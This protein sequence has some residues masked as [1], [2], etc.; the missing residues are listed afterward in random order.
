MSHH[1]HHHHNQSGKNLKIA[2]FLNL[3]FTILEF[4]GGIYVNSVA[5]MSDAVHDLGDSLSL[6]TA[7]YLDKKSHKEADDKYSFGYKRFSLLG[8]LINSIVLI[9]GSI[10]VISE[11]IG[12]LFEPQPSDA[13]GMI[14]FAIIGVLVNG[15]AAWKLSSG[16]SLNEKTVSWHLME[17]VL[18][19]VAV[20]IVAI[21]LNFTDNQYLDPALS[22]LITLYILYN[23]VLRLK[24]TLYI[25]LQ[26][27]PKEIKTEKIKKDILKINNI[28]SLHH[29]HIW[30]LEGENHVFSAHIKLKNISDFEE[31]IN[32]KK[33]VKSVLKDYHFDHY[34]IETELDSETCDLLLDKKH[35]HVH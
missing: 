18:G 25:F 26:G 29:T 13:Q 28:A 10:Y 6:G 33:Q 23:V 35:K 34:T 16:N 22:I 3:G 24:E 30:S 2:F 11:A 7:W 14:V 31:L 27:V 21:V 19:W 17:D 32:I 12:R 1:H 20:L 15:Y 4:F 5:I 9:G 8:A